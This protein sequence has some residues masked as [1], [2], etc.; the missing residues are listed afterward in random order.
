MI[1]VI[2]GLI[3]ILFLAVFLI[4]M[5]AGKAQFWMGFILLSIT[6]ATFSG[7]L[8]CGWACPINT[9][10]RPFV[11]ISKK[12]GLQ[13]KQGPEVLKSGRFR[14]AVF[15]LFL[16]VLGYTIQ[17]YCKIFQKRYKDRERLLGLLS[18]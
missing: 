3:Q 14:M 7:R 11:W 6:L 10:M 4:L 2:R 17:H 12:L 13:R 15:V 1:K 18:L 16:V 9:V 8:Y 5:F